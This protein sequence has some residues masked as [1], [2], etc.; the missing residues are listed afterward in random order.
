MTILTFVTLF[1]AGLACGGI[2]AVA[3][4]ATLIGFPVLI[5]AGLP[6]VVANASNFIA[7]MPGYAAAIPTYMSELREM[8]R[9]ALVH[10]GCSILGA[11]VGS[12]L[13]VIGDDAI[14]ADLVPY[15][16]LIATMLYAFSDPIQRYFA[17]Q[18]AHV[19]VARPQISGG[20]LFL[21]CIYGGYFGAG[22]G[23]ILFAVL[24]IVGYAEFH[25]ANALKNV[26]VTLV[27]LVCIAIFMGSSL[28]S[29]PEALVMMVGSAIGGYQCAKYAKRISPQHLHVCVV[30][31]GLASSVYSFATA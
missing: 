12:V 20:I 28:I 19:G 26:V 2:N 18:G 14:F 16:I 11:A 25:R 23:I 10:A 3:G 31:F 24:K 22:L 27:S 13:L 7:T 30:L 6:P 29:W 17:T 8:E 1:I 21:I 15:L 4:G 5:A 9:S